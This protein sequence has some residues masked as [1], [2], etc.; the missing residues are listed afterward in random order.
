MKTTRSQS[1]GAGESADRLDAVFFDFGGTL[2][3]G[4]PPRERILSEVAREHG[5]D[6]SVGVAR[7]AFHAVDLHKK[8]SS[9]AVKSQRDREKFYSEFNGLVCEAVGISSKYPLMR[10]ALL[11]RFKVARS[12]RLNAGVS[13]LLGDMRGRGVKMAIV[14]NWDRNLREIVERL[15]IGRHFAGII[16][17]V[18][19]GA[20]KPDAR[21]FYQACEALSLIPNQGRIIHVGDDY[22][23]DVVGA[24]RAGIEPVLIDRFNEYPHADC[25]KFDSIKTL[26][27]WLCGT[28]AGRGSGGRLKAEKTLERPKERG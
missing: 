10:S 7:S 22:R 12:W 2:V 5:I 6:V 1:D 23:L 16:S 19:A 27:E 26:A 4:F 15:R 14:A 21:I 9:L 25:R 3:S 28:K 17:S 20:E 13:V 11:A 8:Y 18:E 24:R